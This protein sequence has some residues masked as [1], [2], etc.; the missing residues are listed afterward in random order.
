MHCITMWCS[1]SIP[2][3]GS[4][5]KSSLRHY[6]AVMSFGEHMRCLPDPESLKHHRASLR[7]SYAAHTGTFT[8]E[9]VREVSWTLDH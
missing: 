3:S 9:S 2:T 1:A 6:S 7:E 5:L 4:C 8:G